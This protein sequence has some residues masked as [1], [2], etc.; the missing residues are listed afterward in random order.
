MRT[1]WYVFLDDERSGGNSSVIAVEHQY[2]L[3]KA[4]L[5]AMYLINAVG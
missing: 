2:S 5:S 1:G 4:A 3:H